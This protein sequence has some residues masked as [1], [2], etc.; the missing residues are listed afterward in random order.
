MNKKLRNLLLLPICASVSV[1]GFVVADRQ[2]P[3][4]FHPTPETKTLEEYL[5]VIGPAPLYYKQTTTGQFLAAKFAQNNKDWE[6]ASD[7]LH[8]IIDRNDGNTDLERQSMVVA[9]GS[10]EV[11]RAIAL[12]RKLNQSEDALKSKNVLA[13]LFLVM[14]AFKREDYIEA[15]ELLDSIPERSLGSFVTPV[16]KAW[17][18]AAEGQFD[19]SNVPLNS[20]YA[21]HA[22]LIGQLTNKVDSA[23]TFATQSLKRAD[24]D[25]QDVAKIADLYVTLDKKD[26][27]E[28]LYKLIEKS[29]Y[30]TIA[31]KKRLDA[32]KK[33]D[34][35][36]LDELISENDV[37]TI[38]D[39]VALV[40]LNMA[41]ILF[42]DYSDDSAMI[43]A[44]MALHLDPDLSKAH[45]I[46]GR[47]LARHE[48]TEEAISHFK[49][50]N[51][52]SKE[53]IAAQ[54]QAADLY[55]NLEQKEKAIEVLE[56][57]YAETRDVN[58][59]IQIAH[60][61]RVAE[62][63]DQA[64]KEYNRAANKIDAPIPE[65]YWHLLYA[66]GMA[67]ERL[68]NFEK[69]EEDLLK[70]IAFRPNH[71]YILN[72][73]GY[74]WADQNINL[75]R[76]LEMIE[77]AVKLKPDDGFIADSLGWV[78]Y[79]MDHFKE[80]VPHLERA[81][82]LEPYDPVINDHLGDAYWQTGRMLEARFQWERALNHADEDE[83]L[84]LAI[85]DKLING[86]TLEPEVGPKE[87]IAETSNNSSEPE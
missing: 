8:K 39:G 78:L 54:M 1:L 62:E 26:K 55:E 28:K 21:Y 70:A 46:L 47:V 76:S 49:S 82:Q 69:S 15:K 79:R 29:G 68:K 32:I 67:H 10:G 36:S 20:L 31:I 60:V 9:M 12:A 2:V 45:Q 44:N 84:K 11:N 27:A 38:Q 75:D 58:A 71:P 73:L 66:R 23:T 37:Q 4:V 77:K 51:K 25:P 22:L 7:F 59:I 52:N 14:D 61:Y 72:Y 57:L 85:Q 13:F 63:F 16:L 48:R 81:V 83:E 3:K 64:I 41:E 56:A 17:L 24:I 18:K 33:D 87:M 43:F 34:Q 6:S 65:E 19:V 74:S 40:F 50:I 42:R 35:T 53:Y 86:F 80:A 30:G 5:S